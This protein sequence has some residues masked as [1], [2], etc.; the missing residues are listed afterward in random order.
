MSQEADIEDR[1]DIDHDTRN[2]PGSP[3]IVAAIL[4]KIDASDVF[5]A[6]VTPLV[7]SDRGKHVSNPNVLIEL[8]YAKKALGVGR[9]I[10]VW[11]TAFTDCTVNDLPFD[12]R[13][14]RGPISY[15]LEEGASKA[16]LAAARAQLIDAF[17]DR[18]GLCLSTMSVRTS[19]KP[20][21]KASIEGDSSI[22][23]APE[24]PVP[25]NE[26]RGSGVKEFLSGPR[27]YVRILPTSFDP[28]F[29]DQGA[30]SIPPISGSFSWGNTKGGLLTY[31]GSVRAE[32]AS[33]SLDGATMWF[34]DT[35]EVWA[36]QT[37]IM[38]QY[39]GWLTFFGDYV[40]EKW[41]RFL[42]YGLNQLSQS[43]GRGPYHVRLGVTG[44]AGSVWPDV[45]MLG[46]NPPVALE[47]AIECEFST[48]T[49]DIDDWRASLIGAW[50]ELRRA[51]SMPPPQLEAIDAA[52][53]Q[54]R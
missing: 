44:L 23:I 19:S 10:S 15:R 18:I 30:H 7:I 16:D 53:A 35:G 12:L 42:W 26:G 51:F 21:W 9:V 14:R 49:T 48:A 33:K 27:W 8:G 22:W 31:Q 24:T 34:R 39:K 43:G 40:P 2:V 38:S 17:V 20:P 1:L 46:G 28:Q 29:M 52:F 37:G 45:N 5:V 32:G 50:E 3:D 4:E 47:T 25:I 41:A 36:T 11:N 6:D 54:C 13:G